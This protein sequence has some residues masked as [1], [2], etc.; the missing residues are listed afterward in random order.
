MSGERNL[1]ST[2]I[3]IQQP[4]LERAKTRAADTYRTFS[5][6]VSYLIDQDLAK[7]DD[8]HKPYANQRFTPVAEPRSPAKRTACS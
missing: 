8:D 7:N 4:L 6:Y 1:V 5:Q 3:S 2:S